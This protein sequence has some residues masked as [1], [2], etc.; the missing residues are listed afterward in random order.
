MLFFLLLTGKHADTVV[1]RRRV[2]FEVVRDAS[3]DTCEGFLRG[4]CRCSVPRRDAAARGPALHFQA[5]GKELVHHA[6]TEPTPQV[7]DGAPFAH[8]QALQKVRAELNLRRLR[9]VS[10]HFVHDLE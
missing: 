9:V 2:H 6:H 7:P 10:V 1:S 4:Q 3:L 5:K 8:E